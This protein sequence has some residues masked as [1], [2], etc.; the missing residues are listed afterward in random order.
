MSSLLNLRSSCQQMLYIQNMWLLLYNVN[1]TIL[2]QEAYRPLLQALVL[3]SGGGGG[4]PLSWLVEKGYSCPRQ[5]LGYPSWVPPPPQTGLL[6]PTSDRARGYPA[7][8]PKTEPGTEPVTG[9]M[10]YPPEKDQGPDSKWYPNPL[11]HV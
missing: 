8:A 10:G 6:D 3:L 11:W 9:L 4:V 5:G 7:P 1:K 2:P